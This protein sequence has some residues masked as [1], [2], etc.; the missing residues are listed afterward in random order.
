[1][2][3]ETTSASAPPVVPRTWELPRG[4]KTLAVNGYEMAYTERGSGPPVVLVHGAGSDFRYWAGQME[5]FSAKYRT[6]A[7]SLRH[8][9]PEPWRGDGEFNLTEHVADLIAFIKQLGSG[10][11]HLV[12]HSRGATAALHAVVADPTIARTLVFAEGGLG[13]PGFAPSNSSEQEQTAEFARSLRARFA[14]GDIDG[15]LEAYMARIT[16]PGAWQLIPED[17][18]QVLRDNAWTLIA[19]LVDHPRWPT[20]GCDDTRRL[21]LRVLIVGGANSLPR[22]HLLLDKFQSCLQ[23]AERVVIP[24]ATHAMSLMNPAAFNSAVLAFLDAT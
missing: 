10:A 24:D 6:I 17:S 18:R 9:Y 1:M 23:R 7:V 13:M 22:W 3:A 16:G 12:G 2:H 5:P 8:Y 14:D 4:V 19:G 15:G 11:V 21:N 20:L